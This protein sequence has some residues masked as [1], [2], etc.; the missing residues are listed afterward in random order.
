[1]LLE[2]GKSI[3]LRSL[4]DF[5]SI[6]QLFNCHANTIGGQA[7]QIVNTAMPFVKVVNNICIYVYTYSD[8]F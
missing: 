3:V 2:I 5:L 7:E 6:M 4:S 1:M 8:L